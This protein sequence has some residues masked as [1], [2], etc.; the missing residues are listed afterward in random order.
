MAGG[1]VLLPFETSIGDGGDGD[2][3][4]GYSVAASL[5]CVAS[6]LY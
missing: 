5:F 1:L 3:E 2:A 4:S 6:V